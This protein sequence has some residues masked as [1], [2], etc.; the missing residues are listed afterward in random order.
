[1]CL[2]LSQGQWDNK[3]N[4]RLMDTAFGLVVATIADLAVWVC[5]LEE[6]EEWEWECLVE[7]Y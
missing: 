2:L 5:M 4:R 7:R 1:M 3:P 6:Q